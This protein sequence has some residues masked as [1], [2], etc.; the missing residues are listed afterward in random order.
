MCRNYELSLAHQS[1]R[2]WPY[3]ER[4]RPLLAHWDG[5]PVSSK[6]SEGRVQPSCY[7]CLWRLGKQNPVETWLELSGCWLTWDR[8]SPCH[9]CHHE[10]RRRY[11]ELPMLWPATRGFTVAGSYTWVL[12]L[13]SQQECERSRT[14]CLIQR[15]CAAELLLWPAAFAQCP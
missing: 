7:P 8:E 12:N 11:W 2:P 13:M 15:S 14:D 9:Y 10:A 1:L 4:K 6:P 5:S 3:P